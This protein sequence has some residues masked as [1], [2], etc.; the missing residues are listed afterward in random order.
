MK[1]IVVKMVK[2]E[3]DTENQKQ[4]FMRQLT[5]YINAETVFEDFQEAEIYADSQIL[6]HVILES[7]F[8]HWMTQSKLTEK[9]IIAHREYQ[10]SLTKE[11][12]LHGIKDE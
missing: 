3:I 10:K 8:D 1:F 6:A 4:Y 9:V 11:A 12:I 2:Q 7:D 5:K